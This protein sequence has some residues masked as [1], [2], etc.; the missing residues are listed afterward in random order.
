MNA[1]FDSPHPAVQLKTILIID[2]DVH[3]AATLALGLETNG[4]RTLHAPNAAI[5][6]DLAHAH[7]P[8]LILSD[9]EMP[10]KDGRR[11]LQEMRA[12]PELAGRQF[13]L[14]TGK[15]AFGN[16]R[17]A[18][19]LGADDF[20]LKPFELAEL[21]RCVA[22]RLKRAEFSR[23]IDDG[24][25][26][27]LRESLRSTLPHEFFTPLAGILGLS[28]LCELD[29]D[30]LTPDEIRQD[31]RDIHAAGRRLHRTLRNYLLLLE[32]EPRG[33]P[34]TAPLLE[35]QEVADAL[36]GGALAAG[37]RHR[38]AGDVVTDL[39]GMSLRAN[40]TDLATLVEELVDNALSFSRKNTKV[41]VRAWSDGAALQI[42]VTDV[43]RGLTPSQMKSL[44][45][46]WQRPRAIYQKQSLGLGLMLVHR[47]VQNLGG[48][49][50]LASDDG[51][52]TVAQV[53][54]PAGHGG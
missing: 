19:D 13:V 49:F 48:R 25:V 10:G 31:L 16:Q 3:L 43:G 17:T 47:I 8:D 36:A 34:R 29:L 50:R 35:A 40:P 44:D 1:V 14:M 21:L 7:L 27:R 5:G 54:L 32:L 20:L 51:K 4:Y 12:D 46:F 15:I 45:V 39:T 30:K 53:T 9:I 2:D 26:E 37:E 33:L 52:G 41:Q 24:A 6:W 42:T 23:R 28:E 11:L 18:M 38:R 22:A